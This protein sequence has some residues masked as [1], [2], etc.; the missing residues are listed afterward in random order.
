MEVLL[1]QIEPASVGTVRL[2]EDPVR[3]QFA[4]GARQPVRTERPV[5]LRIPF[6]DAGARNE[7]ELVVEALA[8]RRVF[9]AQTPLPIPILGVRPGADLVPRAAQG[10]RR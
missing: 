4:N 3:S 10:T 7:A 2:D 1:P 8:D 6:I 9:P 5:D